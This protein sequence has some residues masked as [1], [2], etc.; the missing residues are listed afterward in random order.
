[1]GWQPGGHSGTGEEP[2]PAPG[3]LGHGGPGGSPLDRD[4]RLAGF[5]VD[6]EW[7]SLPAIG[8]PGRRAGSGLRPAVA[9]PWRDP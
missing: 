8:G 9:L 6:G 3:L 4:L 1:M 5:A 2:E 7:D